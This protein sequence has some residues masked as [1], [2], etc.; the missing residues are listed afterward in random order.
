MGC[1]KSPKCLTSKKETTQVGC[2]SKLSAKKMHLMLPEAVM[3][4]IQASKKCH[5]L[6][7]FNGAPAAR[8]S[9]TQKASSMG[10]YGCKAFHKKIC[11][12]KT[13]G[14][15]DPTFD[16]GRFGHSGAMNIQSGDVL[17]FPKIPKVE[18]LFFQRSK[19][20]KGWGY[21]LGKKLVLLLEHLACHCVLFPIQIKQSDS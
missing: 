7:C 15:F 18:V 9:E 17:F 1:N 14:K 16:L 3:V 12:G 11:V 8:F 2:V 6:S 21:I 20:P 13:Q 5:L 19:D 10:R 4:Y